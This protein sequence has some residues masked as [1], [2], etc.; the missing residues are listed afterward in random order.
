MGTR[1][2]SVAPVTVSRVTWNRGYRWTVTFKGVSG[3]VGLM[4]VD[5]T[6]IVGDEAEMDVQELVSGNADIVPGSFTYE[7]QTVRVQ[8]LSAVTGSFVLDMEGYQTPAILYSD[9]AVTFKQKLESLP[10]IYTVKVV[11]EQLSSTYNLYAWTITFTHMKKEVVQGAGDL[12]PLTVFSQ[13]LSPSD[14]ATVQVFQLIQGTHPLQ[15]SLSPLFPSIKYSARVSAYNERGFGLHFAIGSAMTL[16]QPPRSTQA[17]LAIMTGNSLQVTWSALPVTPNYLVDGYFVE[18]YSSAPVPEVQV[19]T[20]SASASLS[21][22]QRITVE[23]DENNLAG[24]F[25]L[26]FNGETT[27]N[28]LWNANPDGDESVA[29]SLA[30]L[31]TMGPVSVSQAQSFKVVPG[32]IVSAAANSPTLTLISGSFSTFLPTALGLKNG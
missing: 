2:V 27:D 7:V 12:P 4:L 14:S 22:I 21:E 31:S 20:T 23:S 25:T 9:T 1:Q 28:I 19:I 3:N 16:G 10:T 6:M 32:L 29:Q 24:Y 17:K 26:E 18:T 30:R 11:R 13:S 5:A 15:I 8:A